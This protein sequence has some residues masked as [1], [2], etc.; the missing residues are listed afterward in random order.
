[1]LN[2]PSNKKSRVLNI[3]RSAIF[4]AKSLIV[5]DINKVLV[6]LKYEEDGNLLLDGLS[7]CYDCENLYD[8]NTGNA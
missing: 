6:I 1:M 7:T 5:S 2:Q 3:I 8:R 4:A